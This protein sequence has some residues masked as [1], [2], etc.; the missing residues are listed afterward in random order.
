MPCQASD[1]PAVLEKYST[2]QLWHFPCVSCT[3]ELSS[4]CKLLSCYLEFM[5]HTSLLSLDQEGTTL[6]SN[7]MIEALEAVRMY[8]SAL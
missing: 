7:A 8:L 5:V 1:Q 2:S 6:F 4:S 3:Q